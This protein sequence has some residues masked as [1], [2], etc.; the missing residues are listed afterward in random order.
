M[1]KDPQREIIN[2]IITKLNVDFT[3][4]VSGAVLFREGYLMYEGENIDE[5][6]IKQKKFSFLTNDPNNQFR[7]IE[8]EYVPTSFAGFLGAV[9]PIVEVYDEVST[10]TV[11][12]GLNLDANF[13]KKYNELE[14]L[15]RN[16]AKTKR[17]Y[18]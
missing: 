12:F 11:G 1:I 9:E 15:K 8:Q 10:I 4:E 17:R 3:A 18:F 5:N 16:L 7:V 13:I 6:Q 2:A 14:K